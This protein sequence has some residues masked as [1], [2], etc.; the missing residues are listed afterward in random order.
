MRQFVLVLTICGAV[1]GQ[2]MTEAGAVMAGTAVGSA[3]GKKVSEGV[4]TSLKK[5]GSVLESATKTGARQAKESPST[6]L[7]QVGA[8]VPKA[9]VNN[10]PPPPPPKRQT[11]AARPAPPRPVTVPAV[12]SAVAP[13]PPPPPADVDLA[14]IQTGMG[15]DALLALGIP[16]ARITMYE[17]GHLL[18]IYQYRNHTL[19]SGTVRLRD[20]AVSTVVARP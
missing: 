11:V 12:M 4:T 20:G 3:A 6:P 1:F 18:E 7:L 13:E 17:D 19:A 5:T 16:S 14:A 15:R 10:V 2:T 8:G 9:E